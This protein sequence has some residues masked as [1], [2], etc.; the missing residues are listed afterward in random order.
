MPVTVPV[1][2]GEASGAFKASAV[3]VAEDT[4]LLASEVLSTLPRP[5]FAL[6]VVASL[7]PVPP[8]ATAIVPTDIRLALVVPVGPVAPAA[9]CAPVAPV[10]PVNP[11]VPCGPVAPVEPVNPC[12]PTE[13]AAPA[14]PAAPWLPDSPVGP[15]M[16]IEP[17]GHAPPAFGPKTILLVVL[18]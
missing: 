17:A 16:L 5:I 2:A 1:N 4:G 10:A 8:F 7:D 6:A 15:M 13:P 9:P 18:T 14:T 11:V 3:T 12:G